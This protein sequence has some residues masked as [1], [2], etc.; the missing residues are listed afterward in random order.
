MEDKYIASIAS[1]LAIKPNQVSSTIDLL[2][3]GGTV[4]F[5]ARYRKEK[6]G[7]LDEVKITL[8]RDLSQR[9]E[10]LEKRRV[11]ILKTIKEQ[12]NLTSDL[13][14]KIKAADSVQLLE[15]IYL[16][17]KP[18]RKTK[19]TIAKDKGL[20]PLATF[21]FKQT[22]EDP[23]AKASVFID[24]EKGVNNTEEALQGARD[25]IAEWISE[26]ADARQRLRNLFERTAV[27]TS[28]SIKS[29]ETQGVKYKDYFAWSEPLS[30]TPSH[31][32][33]AMRR[34]EKEAFLSLDISIDKD[35]AIRTIEK[36]IITG[37]NSS[38]NH[39]KQAI[40]DA[41]KR[42]LKP[43]LETELRLFSKKQ[44]DQDAINVFSENIR[45]LLLSAPLG[46]KSIL[47]VDP[48]FRSGCKVVCLNQEGKLLEHTI[49]Y[50]NEPQR[51]TIEAE[52][53]LK[54]LVS[55]YAIEAIAIGN[56]TASR[57]SENFVKKITFDRSLEVVVVNESGASI[58]SASEIAREE[59]PEHDV[60]VRGAVSIG[61]RLA[62]PLAELVKIDPKSIGVGQYQHDVDQTAL[63]Q[64]LDDVVSSCVNAVGVEVNTASKQLLTYVSGL[65]PTLAQNII[66]YRNENGS[67]NS[68]KELLKVAR[69]GAKVYEQAAGFL[70]IQHG[71]HPLDGSAVHPERY[72]IAEKIATDLNINLKDLIGNIETLSTVNLSN[73]TT[74]DVGLPTLKDIISELEKPGRDPRNSFES[75]SFSDLVHEITDLHEG[76]ELPGIVTNVTKFGAFVDIGVHQDG[77][78][79]ISELSN[80][81]VK[82]PNEIVKVQQKVHVK[83]TSVD[84]QRKRI[85]LS[86]KTNSSTPKH[87]NKKRNE[88]NK[89][90]SS[91]EQQLNALKGKWS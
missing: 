44:A 88:T 49:I 47:A 35:D 55:K 66:A 67:F 14:R 37:K 54:L 11:F 60:T 27:I 18:K 59:F 53:K 64:G 8:I 82:D 58:Y 34:G 29:K 81:F 80:S 85:A 20:E 13:E 36:M 9:Y 42:L 2:N 50:P 41:Y 10:E 52:E 3:A 76:M 24:K 71:K 73:Y 65:G 19:S 30:K 7:E 48:G 77:L 40:E 61:R 68:R 57:E 16:P 39:V 87:I 45:E 21:I 25:I 22:L 12:G 1:E 91:M 56:G 43:S 79:H 15:D 5:I 62:D 74:K 84:V 69:M 70:R 26:K 51:K 72:P 28:K 86:M 6:T 90:N 78:V 17:F 32:L 38:A 75:F 83:V 89:P 23:I 4:P 46:Q 33:L 63:K 31:R